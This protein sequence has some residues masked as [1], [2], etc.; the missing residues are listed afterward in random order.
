[1]T[2]SPF[3]TVIDQWGKWN[4][5]TFYFKE[6]DPEQRNGV[7]TQRCPLFFLALTLNDQEQE[8]QDASRS[9]LREKK[10]SP[11]TEKR[12]IFTQYHFLR[13]QHFF[14]PTILNVSR[15]S[16]ETKACQKQ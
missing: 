12:Y 11:A 3:G 14:P 1:M 2:S 16:S 8:S 9:H 4:E 13:F 7:E 5:K 15:V 10:S 6:I